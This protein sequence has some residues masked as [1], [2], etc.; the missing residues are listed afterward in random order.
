MSLAELRNERGNGISDR[1]DGKV[2]QVGELL[3]EFVGNKIAAASKPLS[4]SFISKLL[5]FGENVKE[6]KSGI[7]RAVE[8]AKCDIMFSL[9]GVSNFSS[10]SVWRQSK[11]SFLS[12]NDFG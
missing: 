11:Q 12:G 7:I 6:M 1:G 9:S 3:R 8:L 5:S 2:T 10:E 4:F